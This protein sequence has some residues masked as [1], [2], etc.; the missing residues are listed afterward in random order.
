MWQTRMDM[1]RDECRKCLRCLELD[2]YGNMVSVLRAQG[3]FTDDKKRLLEELTKVLHISNERHRAEVRRAANDEKLSIIAEQL[4]GPNTWTDW[5]IEGRRTIPLLPRLKAHTAFT[6]LANSLSLVIATANEKKVP[7]E[8]R[9]A[10]SIV[11]TETSLDD[12]PPEKP[13]Q[14]LPPKTRGRK[15]KKS[16]PDNSQDLRNPKL[17]TSDMYN[18]GAIIRTIS[19]DSSNEIRS[20][21][22]P[23][24]SADVVK[25]HETS[26]SKSPGV[27]QPQEDP[28]SLPQNCTVP[29]ED[30]IQDSESTST[31]AC[32]LEIKRA[33]DTAITK[34]NYDINDEG[35]VDPEG[36]NSI[37]DE[38]AVKVEVDEMIKEEI[39]RIEESEFD[40]VNEDYPEEVKVENSLGTSNSSSVERIQSTNSEENSIVSDGSGGNFEDDL[41]S[42]VSSSEGERSNSKA[43]VLNDEV[44][45]K[46]IKLNFNNTINIRSLN[47]SRF[48][49]K[50]NIIMVQKG[51]KLSHA[52][53][54]SSNELIIED[55]LRISSKPVVIM[56]EQ[57]P[58]NN[59]QIINQG[60]EK[61]VDAVVLGVRQDDLDLE[62]HHEDFF[63]MNSKTGSI[64]STGEMSHC[65]NTEDLGQDE[66]LGDAIAGDDEQS[67]DFSGGNC[68][69]ETEEMIEITEETVDGEILIEG[70]SETVL[71]DAQTEIYNFEPTD[72]TVCE[73]QIEEAVSSPLDLFTTSLPSETIALENYP[74]EGS[75]TLG[76]DPPVQTSHVEQLNHLDS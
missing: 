66:G 26:I 38:D 29:P 33:S 31:I 39:D 74:S 54:D 71:M 28:P 16:L 53:E 59:E 72:D 50:K 8:E 5:A 14:K 46:R 11:K 44:V 60:V 17:S 62:N 76:D 36:W 68:E 47:K 19:N 57:F 21:P 1:T 32:Q 67:N 58:N 52:G 42:R 51:M 63:D 23:F 75:L 55:N 73:I 43:E 45:K 48:G 6:G 20:S 70:E 2:A 10:E 22:L 7:F 30:K 4:N 3:P 41:G 37:R 64:D 18:H 9:R 15:R 12:V 69:G 25:N 49:S 40:R 27:P 34:I 24:N 61:S 35:E 13:L 56:P 65:V